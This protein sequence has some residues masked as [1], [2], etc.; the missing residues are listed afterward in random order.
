VAIVMNSNFRFTLVY[1]QTLSDPAGLMLFHA[2]LAIPSIRSLGLQSLQFYSIRT[3]RVL[4]LIL[5]FERIVICILAL[6]GRI[7]ILAF[8]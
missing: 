8:F 6:L 2:I 1:A 5:F 4:L 7:Q 3:H